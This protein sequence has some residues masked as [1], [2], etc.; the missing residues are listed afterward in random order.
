MNLATPHEDKVAAARTR[1][2]EVEATVLQ[3]L[4]SARA[5]L[6]ELEE[7]NLQ[8]RREALK[9]N[10]QFY[11]EQQFAALLKVSEST[12]ARLRKAGKITPLMVGGQFRYSSLHVEQSHEI[13]GCTN[14]ERRRSGRAFPRRVRQANG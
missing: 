7:A 2:G 11:T 14:Q 10:T 8:L 12:I 1:L 6:N 4:A 5:T 9:R 13:F 3:A